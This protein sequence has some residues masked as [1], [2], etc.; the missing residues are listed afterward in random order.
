MAENR[1]ESAQSVKA[2]TFEGESEVGSFNAMFGRLRMPR[3]SCREKRQFTCENASR[4]DAA[5]VAGSSKGPKW[6]SS[7]NDAID[8]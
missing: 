7:G 8:P 1:N 6:A 4:T 3:D 5:I 2:E